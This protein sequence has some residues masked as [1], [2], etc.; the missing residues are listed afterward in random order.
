[1]GIFTV[2]LTGEVNMGKL[3]KPNQQQQKKQQHKWT[4]N[5]LK[6]T[7]ELIKTTVCM[8][9]NRRPLWWMHVVAQNMWGGI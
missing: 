9:E 1:M 5:S 4:K 7:N 2:H 3:P 6:W 8:F